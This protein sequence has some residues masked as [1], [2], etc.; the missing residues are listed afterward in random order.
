MIEHCDWLLNGAA[1]IALIGGSSGLGGQHV[2][3]W[4]ETKPNWSHQYHLR[5]E[6]P[7]SAK[8][9]IALLCF[10]F[11]EVLFGAVCQSTRGEKNCV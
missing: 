9:C 10:C 4:F 6:I 3:S 1:L 5:D 2:A 8:V 7:Q 11:Y